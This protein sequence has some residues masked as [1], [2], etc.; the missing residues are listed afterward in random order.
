MATIYD[1][2]QPYGPYLAFQHQHLPKAS[3][4][5]HIFTNSWFWNSRRRSL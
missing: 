4:T 2:E 3:N 1:I 5:T